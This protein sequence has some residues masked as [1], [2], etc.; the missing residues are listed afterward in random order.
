MFDTGN[1]GNAVQQ[2]LK[3]FVII[4]ENKN[5]SLCGAGV[6]YRLSMNNQSMSE[7]PS[8]NE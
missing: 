5:I 7:I 6:K 3:Q 1:H 2:L 8:L 4:K